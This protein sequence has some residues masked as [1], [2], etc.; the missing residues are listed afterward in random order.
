V[1]IPLIFPAKQQNFEQLTMNPEQQT[2]VQPETAAEKPASSAPR[3]NRRR[4]GGRGRSRHRGPRD[5]RRD[6]GEHRDQAERR[7]Q[8]RSEEIRAHTPAHNH[9]YQKPE[10]SIGRAMEQVQEI[11]IELQK[12]LED[13]QEVLQTLEQVEREKTASEEEI[14]MLRESLLKLQK[15][16]GHSRDRDR[17]RDRDYRGSAPSSRPPPPRPQAA[18][19]PEPEKPA[20]DE[21]AGEEREADEE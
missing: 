8:P 11:Q 18:A 20:D 12:V 1:F 13:M 21:R 17:D 7:E 15:G 3:D 14:E 6:Q 4:R 10:G 5:E 19:A 2:E 16:S 9:T